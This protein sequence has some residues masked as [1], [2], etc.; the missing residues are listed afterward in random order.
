V[1][2]GSTKTEG[3]VA[4]GD[5]QERVRVD[6]QAPSGNTHHE[7]EQGP[8]VATS[9]AERDRLW[10]HHVAEHPEFGEYPKKTERVI[11]MILLDRID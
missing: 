11:P 9:G 3:R 4:I 7:V 5:E 2:L 6:P 1:D 8:R 10:E